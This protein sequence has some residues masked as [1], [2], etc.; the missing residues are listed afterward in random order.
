MPKLDFYSNQGSRGRAR[1]NNEVQWECRE[2]RTAAITFI[3][4]FCCWSKHRQF[5]NGQCRDENETERLLNEANPSESNR[6][7]CVLSSFSACPSCW[8]RFLGREDSHLKSRKVSQEWNPNV[9]FTIDEIGH[10]QCRRTI[11]TM[12]LYLGKAD[13][14]GGGRGQMICIS[15]LMSKHQT[16]EQ[17]SDDCS[18]R[19]TRRIYSRRDLFQWT[20]KH[21]TGSRFLLRVTVKDVELLGGRSDKVET[22]TD[23]NVKEYFEGRKEA[24]SYYSVSFD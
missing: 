6:L 20:S 1:E 10:V 7:I 16:T 3:G 21:P 22:K 2:E 23:S 9:P 12:I 8:R 15:N 17:L 18:S 5:C 19:R 14:E 13:D 4:H 11:C 24:S